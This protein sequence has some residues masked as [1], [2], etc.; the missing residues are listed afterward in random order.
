MTSLRIS[1]RTRTR[2]VVLSLA[3]PFWLGG[4]FVLSGQAVGCGGSQGAP[5]GGDAGDGPI[6]SDDGGNFQVSFD[7]GDDAEVTDAPVTPGDT[8]SCMALACPGQCLGSACLTTLYSAGA[9]DLATDGT[10]VY[11]TNPGGAVGDAG[12]VMSVSANPLESVQSTILVSGQSSPGGIAVDGTNVYWTERTSTG[13]IVKAPKTGIAD[14]GGP[15]TLASGQNSPV[16][17]AL[18]ALDVYWTATG[19]ASGTNG[20][21]VKVPL[22]GGAPVTL[23]SGQSGPSGIAVDSDH[24]YW[25]TAPQQLVTMFNDAG[26]PILDSG[27]V[28]GAVLSAPKV[29][30]DGGTI[31]TLATGQNGPSV[32][33]VDDTSLYWTQPGKT[34]G[35]G[36]VLKM[37]KDGGTVTTLAGSQGVLTGLTVDSAHV[38][39]LMV[40]LASMVDAGSSGDAAISTFENGGVVL[41]AAL[42]GGALTTLASNQVSPLAITTDGTSVFWTDSIVGAVFELTPK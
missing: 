35:E 36:A 28:Q 34:T 9:Y 22:A 23:A 41:R 30:V 39:W 4:S 1:S 29:P 18:D 16:N 19:N 37:P 20:T 3:L 14:G 7:A 6:G 8:G 15:V 12:L 42:D 27:V 26:M 32:L 5:D 25:V 31:T 11:W 17:I 13:G 2:L 33:V 24:V 21:V 38:Y 40:G 10:N